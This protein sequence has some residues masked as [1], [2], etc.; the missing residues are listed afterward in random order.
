MKAWFV[1]FLLW[2]I[3]AVNVPAFANKKGPGLV[4]KRSCSLFLTVD[5]KDVDPPFA[6]GFKLISYIEDSGKHRILNRDGNVFEVRTNDPF[7]LMAWVVNGRAKFTSVRNKDGQEI[8]IYGPPVELSS[9][10]QTQQ[11]VFN[12]HQL[13]AELPE[14][15]YTLYDSVHKVVVTMFVSTTGNQAAYGEAVEI[16]Q[17]SIEI[18]PG[19]VVLP[20]SESRFG[21]RRKASFSNTTGSVEFWDIEDVGLGRFKLTSIYPYTHEDGVEKEIE[22]TLLPGKL[23]PTTLIS[24]AFGGRTYDILKL[25]PRRHL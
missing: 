20:Q 17:L 10:N 14:G 1:F 8:P 13:M 12:V 7:E 19:E 16:P 3:A 22:I 4:G 18:W 6:H 2:S 24:V 15:A 11:R 5:D 25:R 23:G 21:E 9:L